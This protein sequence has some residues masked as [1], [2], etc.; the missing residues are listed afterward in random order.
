M[1]DIPNTEYITVNKDGIFVGGKPAVYYR[2]EKLYSQSVVT[3]YFL[4]VQEKYPT[5]REIHVLSSITGG[6]KYDVNENPSSKHGCFLWCRIK[7]S[8]GNVGCWVLDDKWEN[9]INAYGYC[10]P[11]ISCDAKLRL[12]LRARNNKLIQ[13]VRANVTQNKR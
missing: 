7:Y 13:N 3:S 12:L 4:Y 6:K 10:V 11:S 1:T 8:D 9:S 5:I 2:G